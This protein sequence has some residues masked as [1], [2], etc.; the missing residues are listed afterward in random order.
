[1]A[2]EKVEKLNKKRNSAPIPISAR[3]RK[4]P[5]TPKT[6]KVKEDKKEKEVKE[7]IKVEEVKN[8]KIISS[9]K[10]NVRK[11]KVEEKTIKDYDVDEGVDNLLS[12]Q[13]SSAKKMKEQEK[14]KRKKL[15]KQKRENKLEEEKKAAFIFR[16]NNLKKLND[17]EKKYTLNRAFVAMILGIVIIVFNLV[18]IFGYGSIDKKLVEILLKI[19]SM[20]FIL[21]TITIFEFAYH[22]DDGK[23]AMIGTEV[24]VLS[25]FILV[26][27]YIFILFE[28][29][30]KLYLVIGTVVITFYYLIKMIMV[31][32]KSKND[33]NKNI[34]DVKEI[35]KEEEEIEI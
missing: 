9:T 11:V 15:L 20:A 25:I 1:M 6:K 10:G 34:S 17:S 23:L 19:I 27:I 29:I 26:S 28:S 14:D 32:I 30:F 12:E 18:V 8:E 2:K 7:E 31:V 22:K 35:V 3:S 33:H 13:T 21:I 5:F 16:M 24:L 4:K